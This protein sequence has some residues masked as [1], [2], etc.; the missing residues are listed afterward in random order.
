MKFEVEKDSIR[1]T[2][3][4][5]RDPVPFIVQDF[6]DELGVLPQGMKM[7]ETSDEGLTCFIPLAVEMP[8]WQMS[9]VRDCLWD[10]D[11]YGE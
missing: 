2:G 10:I 7:D 1:M 4:R 11:M 6:L 9:Y 8:D 5:E 3:L